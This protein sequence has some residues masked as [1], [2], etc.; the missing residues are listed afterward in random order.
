M[1]GLLSGMRVLDLTQM[2][3]GLLGCTREKIE[4][5][6]AEDLVERPC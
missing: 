5:L 1:N 4:S 3:A 2:P 6:R